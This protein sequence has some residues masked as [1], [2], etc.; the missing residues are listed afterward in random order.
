MINNWYIFGIF[1][2]I[3]ILACACVS[4]PRREYVNK[5]MKISQDDTESVPVWEVDDYVDSVMENAKG[6]KKPKSQAKAKLTWVYV[7]ISGA[8]FVFGFVMF[9]IAYL[10]RQYKA[11]IIGFI[12]LIGA[13]VAAG[14]A[15]LAGLWWTIPVMALIGL[16]AWYITH[17]NREFSIV[18][19]IS[20]LWSRQNGNN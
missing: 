7:I 17:K 19:W 15:E 5:Q 4:L 1:G 8:M 10:S 18:E 14:Y 3:V 20:N 13:G 9:G 12:S 2:F 16:I 6:Y 11:N